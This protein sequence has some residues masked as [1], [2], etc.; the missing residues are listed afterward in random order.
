[1]KKGVSA[2]I[3]VHDQVSLL[4]KCLSSLT[5][6]DE[7][8]ILD[9]A[10]HDDI[11]VVATKYGAIYKQSSLVSI[12]EKIRQDSL[13]YASYEYI[14]FIDP[15]ETI[16]SSLAT[17][18][19]TKISE[20]GV[21][22]FSTPRQNFVF[23]AWV[24]Y[25]RWWPDYQVRIFRHNSVIWPTTLHAQP[26]LKGVEYRL[27]AEPEYA[28]IH[29]NYLSIDEWLDK[30]RRYAKADAQDRLLSSHPYTI[31][32]AAKLSTSEFMSRFFAGEGYRDGMRGLVL[33]ILQSFYYFLVYAYYWEEKKF[34]EL[35]TT[36][37]IKDFPRSWFSHNLRETLYWQ[38]LK[39][40]LKT[41]KAKL[42]RRM[43]A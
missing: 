28:I 10:S 26:E 27:P 7:V 43:I 15:D 20:G 39:S 33:S 9:L 30:N 32:D 8:I 37:A 29:Q 12:V 1:M 22:Y 38:K 23:G 2:I 35:E 16:P 4:K 41:I 21:D 34:A 24:K 18:I 13:K 36:E 25:S 17:L 42:V 6:T 11:K 19:R 31:L 5:W 40:P 14:L 3:I